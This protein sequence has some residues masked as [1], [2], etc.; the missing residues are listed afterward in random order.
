MAAFP[1]PDIGKAK[2]NPTSSAHFN[3]YACVETSP[4]WNNACAPLPSNESLAWP[5]YATTSFPSVINGKHVIIQPWLGYCQ[6]FLGMQNW[7]GGIGAEVGIYV[8]KP[9]GHPIGDTSLLSTGARLILEGVSLVGGNKLWWPDPD[10]TFDVTFRVT[11]PKTGQVF[12]AK[13]S[14]GPTYWCNLWM[15]PNE[16]DRY[17]KDVGGKVPFVSQ[18]HMDFT[19]GGESFHWEGAGPL[20]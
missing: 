1:V 13:S 8:L 7:P 12:L 18:Y 16:Y 6:K 19:V 3:G 20:G 11:N 15:Q 2:N 17:S 14:N 5:G 10:S 9:R 4:D